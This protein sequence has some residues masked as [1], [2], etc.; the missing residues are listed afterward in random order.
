MEQKRKKVR[1]NLIDTMIVIFILAVIVLAAYFL[2]GNFDFVFDQGDKAVQFEIRIENVSKEIWDSLENQSLLAPETTVRNAVTGEEIGKISSVRT[3]K[4]RYYSG[5]LQGEDGYILETME[6]DNIY[7]VYITISASAKC[8]DRKVYTV[9]DIRMVI[10]EPVHFK[11]KSYAA[12]AYIVKT[13]IPDRTV[14]Q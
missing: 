3:E 10:G 11:V 12:T 9:D 1:F 13:E 6:S 2:F 5:L 14:S 4:S 8:D 7:D